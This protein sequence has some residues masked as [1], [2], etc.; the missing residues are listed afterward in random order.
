MHSR[1]LPALLPLI[2]VLGLLPLAA[3]GAAAPPP[4]RPRAERRVDPNPP[5][6]TS[7]STIQRAALDAVLGRGLGAF[8]SKVAV[9]PDLVEGRFVGFRLTEL[10]DAELFGSVDIQPGDTLV[11]VNG[12]PIERPEQAFQA[13]S[14][15]R[16]ASELTLDLLRAGQPRQLRFPI[17]D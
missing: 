12:Q 10:H 14:S 16:V 13:W 1:A 17:V 15:L 6:V 11:A 5:V 9:E 7:P 8:L 4:E 3:C 2:L